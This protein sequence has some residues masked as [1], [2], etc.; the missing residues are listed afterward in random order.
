MLH[1]AAAKGDWGISR[2]E[3]YRDNLETTRVLL[4]EGR[5][6]GVTDWVFYSRVSTMGPSETP[7]PE[8][9]GSDP[10]NPYGGSKP[11][12][13]KLFRQFADENSAARILVV[14]PSVVYGPGNPSST[15]IYRLTLLHLLGM[16]LTYSEVIAQ[17]TMPRHGA[18]HNALFQIALRGGWPI[19][20]AILIKVGSAMVTLFRR[21]YVEGWL[22]LHLFG[23]F[24]FEEYL[25]NV[26]I[27]ILVT[28]IL[29]RTPHDACSARTSSGAEASSRT[30]GE[31]DRS[32]DGAADR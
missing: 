23:L 29:L 6:A 17:N 10:I 13:E 32:T 21:S 9:A 16:G 20:L 28:Y 24:F 26:T 12:A 7:I 27:V 30:G 22:F 18:T 2:E 4:R 11:E 19:F 1:L 25:S 31:T 3:Y 5:K 8:D 15:N 14:R